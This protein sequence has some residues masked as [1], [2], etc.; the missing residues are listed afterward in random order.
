[1]A[2]YQE[3]AMMDMRSF[4]AWYR[5]DNETA[6]IS[7]EA[8]RA[9]VKFFVSHLRRE[10]ESIRSDE[11]D[12]LAD[13]LDRAMTLAGLDQTARAKRRLNLTLALVNAVGPSPEHVLRDPDAAAVLFLDALPMD[14]AE[15]SALVV[16]WPHAD[17]AV[18]RRL[19]TIK[20]ILAPIRQFAD[21]ISDGVAKHKVEKWMTLWSELP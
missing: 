10:A 17:L 7:Q 21:R 18:I 13:T 11:W 8:H 20:G 15:A 9:L 12:G 19:R 2:S 16:D 3:L 14:F 6:A 5:S 1:M 4:V